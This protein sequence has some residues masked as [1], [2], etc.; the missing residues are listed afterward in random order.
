MRGDELEVRWFDIAPRGV[1]IFALGAFWPQIC[2][3]R[4]FPGLPGIV[5]TS[6]LGSSQLV[7]FG[8]HTLLLRRADSV[9]RVEFQRGS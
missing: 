6:A 1:A 8:G 7:E 3:T 4:D 2:L 5:V 9:R